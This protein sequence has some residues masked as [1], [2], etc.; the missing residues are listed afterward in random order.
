MGSD[1]R[2]A[3]SGLALQVDSIAKQNTACKHT[4]AKTLQNQGK[5]MYEKTVCGDEC[6]TIYS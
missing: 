3:A 5:C 2:C 1:K 6:A 4:R